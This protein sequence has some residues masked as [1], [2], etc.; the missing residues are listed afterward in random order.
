M[1]AGRLCGIKLR[2]EANELDFSATAAIPLGFS[3]N[4]D[5]TPGATGAREEDQEV[6]KDG[7]SGSPGDARAVGANNRSRERGA[8]CLGSEA[9]ER[10]RSVG[11]GS[12][13]AVN[14]RRLIL[15]AGV[16]ASSD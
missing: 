9:R 2:S 14:K 15:T 4:G 11:V 12:A 10:W 6:G 16:G 3:K 8:A 7:R 1:R 13:I 5:T